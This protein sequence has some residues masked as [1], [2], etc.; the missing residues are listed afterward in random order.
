MMWA[1][2][3]CASTRPRIAC[4]SIL[5]RSGTEVFEQNGLDI[6][7]TD[8]TRGGDERADLA[9]TDE[10]APAELDALEPARTSPAADGRRR[11]MDVRGGQD[12]RCL[13]EGDPV[14]GR[15]H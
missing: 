11:E 7:G 2:C 8:P 12:V 3:C 13:D 14:G 6:L 4:G 10:P 5:G 1:T 9:T 15:R